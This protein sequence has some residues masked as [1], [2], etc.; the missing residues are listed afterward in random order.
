[1]FSR[2]IQPSELPTLVSTFDT[3]LFL[4]TR[5]TP[6]IPRVLC[7]E[8][9]TLV[10]LT[11]TSHR[12][13]WQLMKHYL[14]TWCIPLNSTAFLVTQIQMKN[15]FKPF[16]LI[17]FESMPCLWILH[18]VR[19]PTCWLWSFHLSK[20]ILSTWLDS[21]HQMWITPNASSHFQ[22]LCSI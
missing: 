5:D 15:E 12:L 13:A 6:H 19:V 8:L 7:S 16:E 3:H 10:S 1:M 18:Q 2:N 14:S 21:I 4:N 17:F 9:K 20:A 11:Q 22:L